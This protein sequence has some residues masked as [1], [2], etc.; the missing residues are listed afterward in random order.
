M[1]TGIF[2]LIV[3]IGLAGCAAVPNAPLLFGQAT[4]LGVSVEAAP[5]GQTAGFVL[6][7]R[8]ANFAIVP[9]VVSQEGGDNQTL[10]GTAGGLAKN[11]GD[12]DAYS[13]LGQFNAQAGTTETTL[14]KFFATGIA[15]RALA[16]GFACKVSGGTDA[17]C[18]GP[19]EGP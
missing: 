19:D 9:T 13:T 14:G 3:L 6:G 8:D 12:E 15:A 16:D 1:K 17:R 5:T 7:Y 18:T 2:G 4:T 10:T 11:G